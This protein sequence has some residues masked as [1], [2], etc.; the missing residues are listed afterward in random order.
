MP[1]PHDFPAT[2]YERL[3]G[4][5]LAYDATVPHDPNQ[6]TE[7]YLQYG[8]AHNAIVWRFRSVVDTDDTYRSAYSMPDVGGD[9]EKRYLQERE[10]F[11]FFA[12][13]V[14]TIEVLC[15]C[16]H[17]IGS[18]ADQV[19]FPLATDD[20]KRAVTPRLTRDRFAQNYAADG[21]T[22]ALVNMVNNYDVANK[23]RNLLSHRGSPPRHTYVFA[24]GPGV[25]NVEWEQYQIDATLTANLRSWLAPHVQ[26]VLEALCQFVEDHLR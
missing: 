17:A 21:I 23:M 2:T 8:M 4:L 12:A 25:H 6:L 13:F 5:V 7:L 3:N 14:S 19:E 18:M 24:G 26:A 11:E 16:A 20:E 22:H 10:L 1:L 15:Y 9:I